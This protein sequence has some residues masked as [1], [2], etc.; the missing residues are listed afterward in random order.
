MRN[1]FHIPELCV[2]MLEVPS[3][4]AFQQC[5]ERGANSMRA[6][7]VSSFAGSQNLSKSKPRFY[8]KAGRALEISR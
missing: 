4:L 6:L 1:I 3:N 5:V 7:E 8:P 2:C